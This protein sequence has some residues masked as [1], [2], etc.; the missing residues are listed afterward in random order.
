MYTASYDN[1]NYITDDKVFIDNINNGTTEPYPKHLEIVSKY[2]NMFPHK[3]GIYIDIGAHIGTTIMPYSKYFSKIIAY[4]VNKP[5]FNLLSRNIKLNGLHDKC[6][7]NN[8]GLYSY[9]CN[10]NVYQHNTYNSGCYY[11]KPVDNGNIVCK[12]LDEDCAIYLLDTCDNVNNIENDIENS[13]TS[14]DFIKID[15]EGS[16]YHVLKGAEK[17]LLKYKPLVQIECNSLSVNLFNISK[18]TIINYMSKLGYLEFD[19]SDSEFNL[20]FYCPNSTLSIIP[21]T[22]YVFWTNP[23][24]LDEK[25]INGLDSLLQIKNCNIKFINESMLPNYILQS[26]PLHPAYQYLSSVHK[27][28]YLRTYFMHFYGGG[29][30]DLKGTS[31]T[32][33]EW[34]KCFEQMQIECD[35]PETHKTKL[36]CG[37][38]EING[39][40]ANSSIVQYWESLIGNGCYI[41]KPNSPFTQK[42][43]SSMITLLDCKLEQLKT[44]PAR[45]NRDCKEINPMYPIEWNEMLGRI[46][47]L[48]CWEF[49]DQLSQTL[50][51]CLF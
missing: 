4:E 2:I 27:A 47:H 49:K 9:T 30:S 24:I 51:I 3:N 38:K 35:I 1:F 23:N 41:V 48:V 44:N 32:G 11:F 17:I 39:G 43:Y 19:T 33:D 31:S 13:N 14:I 22:I 26:Q 29:Y 12:S 20:F 45:T 10:G 36:I 8:Y 42:W 6:I 37:Y 34:S 7:L 50:P 15:T 28:D 16:E 18:N 21:K 46:F 40:V 5:T 25:R